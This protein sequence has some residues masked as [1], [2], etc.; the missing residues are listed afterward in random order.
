[1]DA[2]SRKPNPHGV[3][4]EPDVVRTSVAVGLGIILLGSSI[5]A[6][7]LTFAVFR[8]NEKGEVKKDEASIAAA[9]M[10]RREDAAPPLPRLQVQP[11]RH[12]KEFRSAEVDRLTTYGWMDRTSGVVHIPIDRAIDLVAERGVGPLAPLVPAPAATPTPGSEV[13]K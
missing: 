2:N 5:V 13:K 3:A 8:K 10:E 4:A 1:M 12:W 6:V 9:G 7:V 11:V